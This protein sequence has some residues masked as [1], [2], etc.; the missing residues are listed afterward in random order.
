V[1][2]RAAVPAWIT[3]DYGEDDHGRRLAIARFRAPVTSLLEL[4]R[5]RDYNA[6]TPPALTFACSDCGKFAFS[7]PTRCYWCNQRDQS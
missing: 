2:E 3:A 4:E 6:V 1:S 7:Q 5:L